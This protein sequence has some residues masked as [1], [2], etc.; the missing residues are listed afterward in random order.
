MNK[1]KN[2]RDPLG[3]LETWLFTVDQ[4]RQL[5]DKVSLFLVAQE[6]AISRTLCLLR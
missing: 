1:K 3:E 4:E 2:V 6:T 5:R